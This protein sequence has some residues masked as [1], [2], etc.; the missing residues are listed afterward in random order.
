MPFLIVL[1]APINNKGDGITR[2]PPDRSLAARR[3][4]TSVAGGV[5]RDV[6]VF[7][8][9]SWHAPPRSSRTPMREARL[10]N[11]LQVPVAGIAVT[12]MSVVPSRNS[13]LQPYPNERITIG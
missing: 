11:L 6:L 5:P 1:T 13:T 8:P 2:C 9:R 4:T 10:D 12:G 3:R 7:G